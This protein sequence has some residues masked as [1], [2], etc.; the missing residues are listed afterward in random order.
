MENKMENTFVVQ[1]KIISIHS[2]DRDVTKWPTASQFEMDLP[3]DYKNVVSIRLND[4]WLPS[5]LY[6]FSTLNQNTKLSVTVASTTSVVEIAEGTYSP[7]E[8]ALE[9]TGKL[10]RATTS[11]FNV[12]YN[13]VSNKFIFSNTS[14]F[15][16]RFNAA[17]NYNACG[18]IY[19]DQ[20]YKW[21][22]GSYLGFEKSIYAS[23]LQDIFLPSQSVSYTNLS[24][25]SA[26]NVA[27]LKGYSEVYL[28]L[29]TYNNM[30][31][32][33]Y[34]DRSSDLYN[35][36]FG[37]RHNSSFAKIPMQVRSTR[38]DFL[39]NIFFSEPPLE[40]LQRLR[41][42]MRYHDGRP[43]HFNGLNFNFSI[44]LTTLRNDSGKNY[45]VNKNNYTL[46]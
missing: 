26:P 10:N 1:K 45:Q 16:L 3:I 20:T 23:S 18:Q 24:V 28:E 6:V 37:G 35:G 38:E 4:V 11:N 34:S 15:T 14:V 13:V 40:R 27:N 42:K 22:L 17:E 2:E 39:H 19:Y 46:S 25:V 21:G 7:S 31:E 36:K 32:S 12:I 9:L 30:D 5:E 8:M 29:A 41:F 43:V 44:E 33:F